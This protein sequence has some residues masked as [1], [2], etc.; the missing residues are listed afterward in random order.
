MERVC[1]CVCVCVC[2]FFG[3]F[4]GVI[5]FFCEFLPLGDKNK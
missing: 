2:V 4:L 3:D 1:V 5:F